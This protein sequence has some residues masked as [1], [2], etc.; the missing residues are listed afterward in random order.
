M[1]K[2]RGFRKLHRGLSTCGFIY[3][4]SGFIL[5]IILI[6]LYPSGVVPSSSKE[7]IF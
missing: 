6:L 3:D 1:F 5:T 7:G 4:S 2:G